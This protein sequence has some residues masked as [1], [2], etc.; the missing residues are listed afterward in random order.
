MKQDKNIKKSIL[1]Y[2][3]NPVN[4]VK[5]IF[6]IRSDNGRAQVQAESLNFKLIRIIFKHNDSFFAK[7]HTI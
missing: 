2:P 6:A 7:L 4:P 3:V 1:T 5:K